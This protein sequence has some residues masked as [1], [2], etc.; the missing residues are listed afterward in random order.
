MVDISKYVDFDA[1]AECGIRENVSFDVLCEVLDAA[2][3]EEELKELLRERADELVPNYITV[4]DIFATINYLNCVA[5]ASATPTIL[6]T[7]A[8]DVSAAWA[9]CCKTSSASASPVWSVSSARE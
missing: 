8:T 9:S 7:W 5:A 4:D 1:E 2:Q 3:S 6:I